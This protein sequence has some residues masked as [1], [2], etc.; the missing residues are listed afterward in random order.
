MKT[1]LTLLS[2][3]TCGA[4]FAQPTLTAADITPPFG[5]SPIIYGTDYIAPGPA[6]ANFTFNPGPIVLGTGAQSQYLAPSSTPYGSTFP[7]AT[8]SSTALTNPLLYS[9]QLINSSGLYLLGIGNPS[10]TT[11]YTNSER[12]IAVPLSYTNTW[13]DDWTSTTNY[14]GTVVVR[15]ATTTGTYNGHGTLVLPWGSFNVMRIEIHEV[16]SD[17]SDGI[18]FASGETTTV[19]YYSIGQAAALLTSSVVEIPAL[20]P[21]SY[22]T[23]VLDPNAAGILEHGALGLGFT[24][25]P[26]PTKGATTIRLSADLTGKVRVSVL[27][28]VGREV[29]QLVVNANG[30]AQDITLDLSGLPASMYHVQ[31]LAADGRRGSMPLV[32]E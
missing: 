10:Y 4:A 27:D 29:R 31:L 8:H 3:L 17:V 22:T 16:F 15:S 5:P 1:T 21:P 12:I 6:T 32:V 30:L 18:E 11:V 2:L 7:T 20:G 13:T 14:G 23:S 24:L 26:N 28:L 19:T 9:Y 25:Y